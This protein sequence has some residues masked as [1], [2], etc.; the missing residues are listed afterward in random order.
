MSY[1]LALNNPFHP[2]AKGARIPDQ[3]AFPTG[4]YTVTATYNVLCNN[5]GGNIDFMVT[6]CPLNSI[7]VSAQASVGVAAPAYL[8][9]PNVHPF[10]TVITADAANLGHVPLNQPITPGVGAANTSYFQGA[11][12]GATTSQAIANV[13]NDFRVVGYGARIRSLVAP[14][15]QSG[16]FIM[17]SIPSSIYQP[18]CDSST[19][20]QWLNYCNY[21]VRDPISG[22]TTTQIIQYPASDVNM[23]AELTAEGGVEWSGRVTGPGA[24]VFKDSNADSYFNRVATDALFCQSSPSNPQQYPPLVPPVG[25]GGNYYL[26]DTA[27]QV[28]FT[29]YDGGVNPPVN[30]QFVAARNTSSF[31][32]GGWATLCVRGEGISSG[33]N[34]APSVTEPVTIFSVEVIYHLEGTPAVSENALISATNTG[35]YDPIYFDKALMMNSRLPWFRR[36]VDDD[37]RKYLGNVEVQTAVRG[38]LG[39]QRHQSVL[40]KRAATKKRRRS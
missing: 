34:V 16:Q 23:Y 5:A 38:L 10:G 36:I 32:T 19:L 18:N 31:Q 28:G 14:L 33:S 9:G 8:N 6:P 24:F 1:D 26:S 21:P 37:T 20:D 25:I 2:G 30:T 4:V 15:N 3:H 39:R 11:Y 22:Y 17:A 7:M 35:L 13:L 29:S 40:P 12:G 27:M